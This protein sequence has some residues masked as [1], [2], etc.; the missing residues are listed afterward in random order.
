[1]IDIGDFIRNIASI[2]SI[3]GLPIALYQISGI[4]SKTAQQSF[5]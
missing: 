1:M 5:I 2:C 3:I 4:K